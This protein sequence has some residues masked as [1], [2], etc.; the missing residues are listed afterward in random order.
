MCS[1]WVAAASVAAAAAG[2]Q[3]PAVERS[4]PRERVELRLAGVRVAVEYGRPARRGRP[5]FGALVPYGRLWRTGSDEATLLSTDAD[6]VLDTLAV[7]A[8]R[9]ALF[10]IPGEEWWTVVVNRVADQWGAY[11]YD[12]GQD[13]GRLRVRPSGLREPVEQLT[14][15]LAA[16]G[17]RSALLSLAWET[18][19]VSL[20]VEIVLG[21]GAAPPSPAVNDPGPGPRPGAGT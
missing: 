19:Q 12:P 8:G 16:T 7:P 9:Y 15:T 6:L 21:E 17:E 14:V 13:L 18:T 2:P 4:A 5:I 1:G 20:P 11:G 3:A 10:T